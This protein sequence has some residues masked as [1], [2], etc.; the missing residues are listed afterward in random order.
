MPE[1]EDLVRTEAVFDVGVPATWSAERNT[2]NLARS[3]SFVAPLRGPG[4]DRLVVGRSL[5]VPGLSDG[6]DSMARS[7]TVSFVHADGVLPYVSVGWPGLVG[8]VSGMN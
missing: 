7:V 2:R 8:V 4:G 1:Y 3:L 5:S 6:G